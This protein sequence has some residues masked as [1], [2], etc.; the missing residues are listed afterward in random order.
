MRGEAT[1]DPALNLTELTA[2]SALNHGPRVSPELDRTHHEDRL[3]LTEPRRP[4]PEPRMPNSAG[5]WG[6]TARPR[7]AAPAQCVG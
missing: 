2:C 5:I 4:N 6:V 3:N 7:L 1:A